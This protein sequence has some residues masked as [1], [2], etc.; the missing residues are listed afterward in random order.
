MVSF[1]QALGK[2]KKVTFYISFYLLTACTSIPTLDTNDRYAQLTSIY[3]IQGLPYFRQ[4]EDQ[5]GPASLATLLVAQG[6]DVTPEQLRGKIYIP[7]K[8]GTVTTEIV[9]RARRY[10]LLAYVLAPKL[11]D[12][13]TEINAG[14]PVLVMQNLAFSW[15]PRWHFSVAMAYDL[16][17]QTIS[18][19]SGNEEAHEVSFDLFLKTWSRAQSWAMVTTQPNKLPAT[20]TEMSIVETAN[21]LEQVGEIESALAA[22]KAILSTWPENTMATFGA[23]NS[24]YALA[25]YDEAEQFFVTYLN[26]QR[27]AVAGWNNLAYTFVQQGCVEQAKKAINCALQIEPGNAGL[28]ESFQEIN[29][30]KNEMLNPACRLVDCPK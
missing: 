1:L 6:V 24:A 5:C 28:S 18:L 17:K 19:R 15:L 23:G 13:L 29:Q 12:I 30:F 2:A 3:T 10:G 4:I 26:G 14:N 11:S 8:K 27:D 9:A 22:Y 20:A 7:D 21:A 25:R 16:N